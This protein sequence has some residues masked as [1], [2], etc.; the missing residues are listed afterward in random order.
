[1]AGSDQRLTAAAARCKAP[2]L[3]G[4]NLLVEIT[5]LGEGI[6]SRLFEPFQRTIQA[7]KQPLA[8]SWRTGG[9]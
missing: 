6:A 8:A 1:M 2:Q 3:R 9:K 5:G 7:M 4:G